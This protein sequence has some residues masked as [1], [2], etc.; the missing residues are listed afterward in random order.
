MTYLLRLSG[1]G[2]SARLALLLLQHNVGTWH[3]PLRCGEAPAPWTGLHP[4]EVSAGPLDL[5]DDHSPSTCRV[6][7]RPAVPTRPCQDCRLMTAMNAP[8]C[9]PPNSGSFLCNNWQLESLLGRSA[10][11][12]MSVVRRCGPAH[13]TVERTKRPC[14][15]ELDSVPNA[16]VSLTQ[17][18]PQ[19]DAIWKQ[20]LHTCNWSKWGCTP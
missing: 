12:S 10:C 7:R 14:H 13:G 5:G 9:T 6:E 16:T 15:T 8:G 18:C 2:Q 17:Q 3:Q 11:V 1:P 4:A 19:R 20:G